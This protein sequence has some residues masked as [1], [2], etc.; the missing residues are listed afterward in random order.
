MI[1]DAFDG[2]EATHASDAI[3]SQAD[4][5]ADQEPA[6]GT[7]PAEVAGGAPAPEATGGSSKK[8]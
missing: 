5:R 1:Q 3:W 6:P 4:R 8:P 7:R 2:L